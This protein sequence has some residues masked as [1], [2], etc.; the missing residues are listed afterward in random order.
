MTPEEILHSTYGYPSFRGDQHEIIQHTLTGNDSLVLMPTG[1]GKSLCYQIPALILEG[2]TVVVS[3]LIALMQDQVSALIELGVKAAYINSTLIREEINEINYKLRDNSLDLLYV[4]PERLLQ[5]QFL[6]FLSELNIS[7]FAIDEVHCVSQWGHD[8]RPEYSK[9]S[10]LKE[11][12]P[13]IPRI[14]LTATADV[15]TRNDVIKQLQLEDAKLFVGNFDRPNICY[16]VGIKKNSTKQL[17]NF[18]NTQHRGDSGIV[19]CLSRK[20][21]EKVAENLRQQGFNA[22]PY[23]AG[24]GDSERAENQKRFLLEEEVI[25]VATIAFGMGIDKPNVRFVAHLDLPKSIEA[26]YQETGRAGRDGLPANAW[27]VYG[28]SDVAIVRQMIGSGDADDARKRIEGQKLTSLLG[29]CETTECRR[30]V[31]LSYF[32]QKLAEG[33]CGNCDTCLEPVATWDG[34]LAAKQALS[35]V[36]RT[37]QRFGS[38]YLVDVLTGKVNSRIEN[39]RHDRLAVFGIGKELAATEW[40]SVL[41][42][43][44]AGGY[45]GV[46]IEGYGGLFLTGKST[47]ILKEG[48]EVIFRKDPYQHQRQAQVKKKEKK[49]VAQ[50]LAPENAGLFE[51]LRKHRLELARKQNLPPYVIFHDSTLVE[52]AQRKPETLAAMS[53]ISGVGEKKLEKYGQEFLEL[54]QEAHV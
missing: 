47:A 29:Y 26:Y 27:M 6:S 45:I 12:F 18:I 17:I 24:L 36:Y 40:F 42:Q 2:I 28:L 31:L 3:P 49:P 48:Q 34:T 10:I 9:L 37:G 38:S 8:F 14:A 43:L 39:F 19:Y 7:L 30:S 11:H 54:L 20:K 22:Y 5:E 16:R 53:E 15:P 4:A 41:R 35:A 33:R 21:V 52:M 13:N 32:G 1:G 23:H 25:I 51:K 44:I 46:D 50:I